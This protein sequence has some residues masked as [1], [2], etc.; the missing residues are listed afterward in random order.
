MAPDSTGSPG[1]VP[2]DGRIAIGRIGRPHGIAGEFYVDGCPL[3]PETLQALGAAAG[4]ID[5]RMGLEIE[6]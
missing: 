4:R 6:D 5:R 2:R 3:A 1:S